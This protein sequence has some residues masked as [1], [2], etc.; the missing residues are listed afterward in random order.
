MAAANALGLVAA[1]VGDGV[2]DIL[3]WVALGGD[4]RVDDAILAPAGST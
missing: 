2:Y 3:S 1:L 4:R